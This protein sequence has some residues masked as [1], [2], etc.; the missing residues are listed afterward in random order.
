MSA[1]LIKLD[2]GFQYID[3]IRDEVFTYTSSD[4]EVSSITTLVF[5]VTC[6]KTLVSYSFTTL[7]GVLRFGIKFVDDNRREKIIRDLTWCE[8]QTSAVEDT[9][10]LA[11]T[12]NIHFIWDNS[13]QSWISKKRLNYRI[14]L[15]CEKFET[16]DQRRSRESQTFLEQVRK[17]KYNLLVKLGTEQGN[18]R[19]MSCLEESIKNNHRTLK[20]SK[21]ESKKLKFKMEKKMD[22][23]KIR[24]DRI[25]GICLR[26]IEVKLLRKVLGYLDPTFSPYHKNVSIVCKY[27]NHIIKQEKLSRKIGN[28]VSFKSPKAVEFVPS[29]FRNLLGLDF[30][31]KYTNQNMEYANNHE[32]EQE[33][34]ECD[35]ADEAD[36]REAE[37]DLLE[38]HQRKQRIDTVHAAADEFFFMQ[39]ASI[40]KGNKLSSDTVTSHIDDTLHTRTSE[41]KQQNYGIKKLLKGRNDILDNET[42]EIQKSLSAETKNFDSTSKRSLSTRRNVD[43]R[44]SMKKKSLYRKIGDEGDSSTY[45]RQDSLHDT[46]AASNQII[47]KESVPSESLGSSNDEG[48]DQKEIIIQEKSN[49]ATNVT[50]NGIEDGEVQIFPS[51]ISWTNNNNESN[52]RCI[53]QISC[54]QIEESLAS[55]N[56]VCSENVDYSRRDD[57]PAFRE[58]KASSVEETDM[59]NIVNEH[60][61]LSESSHDNCEIEC[62]TIKPSG[63][64][65][66]KQG[67]TPRK[68]GY[69][70]S[71]LRKIT[72]KI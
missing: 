1:T 70:D 20:G 53:D 51:L 8:S 30:F 68:M 17:Q 21:K 16:C 49:T 31:G 57:I 2:E 48:N 3:T 45:C 54:D 56:D 11:D 65:N 44:N 33:F 47:Q 32:V 10:H 6:E 15:I 4:V 25:L 42:R 5:P 66:W 69:E 59:K 35:K 52:L 43:K 62:G 72:M 36:L 55:S 61:T 50:N 9:I 34:I 37:I 38:G 14:Q 26:L 18:I 58:D 63:Q 23:A 39:Q 22:E 7:Q 46:I 28:V 71:L 13:V 19:E 29:F 67:M 60:L 27:W 24:D 12:G 64:N 41:A 40:L